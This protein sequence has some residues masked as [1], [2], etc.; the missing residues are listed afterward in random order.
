MKIASD[1][2]VHKSDVGGVR[3]EIEPAHAAAVFGELAAALAEHRPGSVLAG[4]LVGPMRRG[5]PSCWSG[6]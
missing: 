1:Q 2:V 6:W 4:V 5:V 3:L